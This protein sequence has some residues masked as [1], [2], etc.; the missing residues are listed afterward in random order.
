MY[1]RI[2]CAVD[3]SELSHKALR[4]GLALAGKTGAEVIVVT[5]TEPSVII[6]PG[7]EIMMVDT[8]A[9]IADL[10]AA[11]AESAKGVL[12]DAEKIAA[13]AGARIKGVHIANSAAADGILHAA[14]QE[15]ADLIVMGSHGRRGLG[16][17]L[18]GS[19]ASEVLAHAELPVLV[20]K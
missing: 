4:H 9:L 7:A 11:K 13:E 16:R 20:V 14:K 18:L 6:A 19:Q 3:G 2:V 12:A 17:L 10:E 15:H 1:S 5:V 8:S